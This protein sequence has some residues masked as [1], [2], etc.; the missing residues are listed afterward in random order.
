[1]GGARL[2][3]VLLHRL[4]PVG[5]AAAEEEKAAPTW[6]EVRDNPKTRWCQITVSCWYSRERPVEIVSTTAVWYHAGKPPA[7]I[8]FVL[9]RDP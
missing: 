2:G 3:A 9:I 1:M 5:R 8:R 4:G 6:E 7:P